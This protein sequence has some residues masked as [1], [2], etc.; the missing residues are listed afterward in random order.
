MNSRHDLAVDSI[1]V[2]EF[3]QDVLK[4]FKPILEEKKIRVNEVVNQILPLYTEV[5]RFREI[6]T[7]IISN[8]ISY[9]SECADNRTVDIAITVTLTDCVV[10]ISDNGIGMDEKTLAKIFQLFYRGSEKSSGAGVG[11]YIT[12]EMINELEGEISVRSE[13]GKGSSFSCVIPNLLEKK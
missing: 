6:L 9:Q 5:N 4:E 3:L 13:V 7:H 10:E 12:R 1:N 2:H 11:L 8:A